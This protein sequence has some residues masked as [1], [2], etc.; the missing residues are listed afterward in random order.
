MGI[1]DGLVLISREIVATRINGDGAVSHKK[2]LDSTG[3]VA[4]ENFADVEIR[5]PP[6][7]D[8]FL[9]RYSG[10]SR[11]RVSYRAEERVPQLKNIPMR[12]EFT[13][14]ASGETLSRKSARYE[15]TIKQPKLKYTMTSCPENQ[16]KSTGQKPQFMI[17]ENTQSI[18]KTSVIGRSRRNVG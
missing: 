12:A 6:Y 1:R 9:H 16:M 4:Y 7:K 13:V 11:H 10:Y 15:G 17:P 2:S 3:F 18:R 5:V 14:R 8:S